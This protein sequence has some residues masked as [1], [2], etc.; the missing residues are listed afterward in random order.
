LFTFAGLGSLI[1]TL[2]AGAFLEKV[3][4][5]VAYLVAAAFV[6][7][8][9]VTVAFNTNLIMLYAMAFIFGIGS[10]LGGYLAASVLITKWVNRG[11]GTMLSIP[12]VFVNIFVMIMSPIVTALI[13]TMG[14]QGS[15]MM[16]GCTCAAVNVIV[17][18]FLANRM[19]SYYNAEPINIGKEKPESEKSARAGTQDMDTTLP[20]GKIM[21]MP[22]TPVVL[23][24]AFFLTAANMLYTSNSIP[25]SM[26]L[27]LSEMDAALVF[28]IYNIVQMIFIF[29]FGILC[30][31]FGPVT[32]IVICSAIGALFFFANSLFT[33]F[34]GAVL[35]SVAAATGMM[36]GLHGAMMIPKMFGLKH[37]STLI[38]YSTFMASI[39][40]MAGPPLAGF[41]FSGVGSYSIA[42]VIGGACM[43]LTL[44]FTAIAGSRRTRL[45][46][47]KADQEYR[48]A[49]PEEA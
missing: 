33:G 38:G 40:A 1:T 5:R 24:C 23:S 4:P 35:V 39:G 13:V 3:H 31:R 12:T 46:I 19:P 2:W 41:I 17:A 30:D 6:A 44:L 26:T 22:V 8:F 43:A 14:F 37:S 48:A 9:Y 18:L 29:G 15:V 47:Q 32:V 28:S 34:V 11:R 16:V 49:H 10:V 7:A 21:K 27:G 25:F 45:R 42:L 36:A 20:I